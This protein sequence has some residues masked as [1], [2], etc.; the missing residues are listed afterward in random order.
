MYILVGGLEH[1]FFMIY[2]I[3]CP[4]D[5]YIFRGVKTTNQYIYI[6]N[7]LIIYTYIQMGQT[8]PSAVSPDHRITETAGAVSQLLDSFEKTIENMCILYKR[9][10]IIYIYNKIL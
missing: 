1:F 9:Y 2:G 4:I 8:Q 7:I 10:K 6:Y 5:W 3:I